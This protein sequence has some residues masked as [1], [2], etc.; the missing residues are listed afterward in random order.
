MGRTLI[1]TAGRLSW[2]GKAPET[3]GTPSTGRGL[4]IG[5]DFAERSGRRGTTQ[6]DSRRPEKSPRADHFDG[7]SLNNLAWTRATSHM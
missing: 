5:K 6:L 1:E 2:T 3:P 4:A 7:G